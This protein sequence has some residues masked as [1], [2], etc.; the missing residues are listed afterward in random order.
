[1]LQQILT[2]V[3]IEGHARR[4]GMVPDALQSQRELQPFDEHP[5]ESVR[6]EPRRQL[7]LE[8]H[9]P[10]PKDQIRLA[11]GEQVTQTLCHRADGLRNHNEALEPGSERSGRSFRLIR[12]GEGE[13][14]DL[15]LRRQAAQ[16]P[17][18]A[19]RRP[20]PWRIRQL[21]CEHQNPRH[22]SA[23]QPQPRAGSAHRH[24]DVQ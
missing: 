3:R 21:W 5:V 18:V 24:A 2:V 10:Q 4:V 17:P 9:A 23:S 16:Q 19:Q 12:R 14:P 6:I 8:S 22:S 15:M 7:R 11:R 13:Q 1:M 20:L